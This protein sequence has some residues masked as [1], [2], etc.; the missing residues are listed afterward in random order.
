MKTA[1]FSLHIFRV[2]LW[3]LLQGAALA[4]PLRLEPADSPVDNPLKGLVP[5]AGKSA[6]RFPHSLEYHATLEPGD[7]TLVGLIAEGGQGLA[8]ANNARFLGYLEG[9]PQAENIAKKR[10]E[11][12]Q[13]WMGLQTTPPQ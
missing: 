1:S 12:T 9:T 6:E 3:L 5:Y 4:A 13:R 8:T 11:W 10:I 7:V 2:A